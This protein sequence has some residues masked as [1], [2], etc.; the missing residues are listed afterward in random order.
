MKSSWTQQI[1]PLFGLLFMIWI[2][3]EVWFLKGT[4]GANRFGQDPLQRG[5]E[6]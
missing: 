3:I 1:I 2:L 6:A 5:E 4:D